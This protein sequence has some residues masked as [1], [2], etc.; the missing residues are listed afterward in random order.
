MQKVQ[1]LRLDINQLLSKYILKITQNKAAQ[2]WGT[3]CD[4]EG[5]AQAKERNKRKRATSPQVFSQT[6]SE[7]RNRR[8]PA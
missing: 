7:R 2:Q 3:K 8:K 4:Q 6:D 5:G 1:V